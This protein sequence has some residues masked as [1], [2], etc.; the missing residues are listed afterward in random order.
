MHNDVQRTQN[1]VLLTQ[2]STLNHL[3]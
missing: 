1:Q 2:P 3:S